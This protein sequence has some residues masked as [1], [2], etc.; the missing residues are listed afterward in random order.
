MKKIL[1][2]LVLSLIT[3]TSI[4]A[5]F[6]N[7]C[8]NVDGYFRSNGTYVAPHVRTLP[9]GNPYNNFSFR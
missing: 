5:S 8:V 7:C 6:A 1:I 9:D 3:I 4:K 2:F